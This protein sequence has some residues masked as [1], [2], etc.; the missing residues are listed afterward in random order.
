MTVRSIL[1]Q[2]MGDESCQSPFDDSRF[3]IAKLN[4]RQSSVCVGDVHFLYGNIVCLHQKAAP[5]V[6]MRVKT[7]GLCF[8]VVLHSFSEDIS[9]LDL[10]LQLNPDD[11]EFGN[12]RN[13]S[14]DFFCKDMSCVAQKRTD[15]LLQMVTIFWNFSHDTSLIYFTDTKVQ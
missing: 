5:F 9:A 4:R 2:L 1:V 15:L 8:R 6:V 11:A 3:V 7:E 13:A 14:G 10:L 12:K